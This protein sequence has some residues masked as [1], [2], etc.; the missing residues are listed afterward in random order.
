[1]KRL[2]FSFALLALLAVPAPAMAKELTNVS[3]CGPDA[4]A[5]ITG[6]TNLHD[7]GASGEPDG[8][9][10][11]PAPFY[12]IR[13]TFDAEGESQQWSSWYVPSAKRLASVDERTGVAWAPIDE[14]RLAV[15]ARSLKP[16]ARP[17]ISSVTIG[18]RKVTDNPASYLRLFTVKSA[19]EAVPQGLADWEPVVFHAKD[20][21]PWTLEQTS[22]FYSPSNGMLQRGIEM[23]KL[24][25]GM[26]E[27]VRSGE[28]LAGGGSGFPWRAVVFALLA[29]AALLIAVSLIR[30][31]RRR[32]FVRRAPTTA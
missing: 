32:V 8:S 28:S 13:Y 23:V 25:G 26:A 9:V 1:M 31:V 27:E 4:C 24:P 5:A 21:T 19:G 17:E 2:V 22:L 3:V 11:G 29:A 15:L 20:K 6:E 30:P 16:F 10:P 18:S 7:F 12:E 14:P